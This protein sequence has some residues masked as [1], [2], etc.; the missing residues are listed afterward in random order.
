M[1]SNFHGFP[2]FKFRTYTWMSHTY[3]SFFPFYSNAPYSLPA[4]KI[5]FDH[6]K[7]RV[8]L[9]FGFYFCEQEIILKK[10]PLRGRVQ[11]LFQKLREN[12]LHTTPTRPM[13]RTIQFMNEILKMK[14]K[15]SERSNP[16]WITFL[17]FK[18]RAKIS[19]LSNS[20]KSRVQNNSK[21]FESF[22]NH[23][24]QRNSKK[25]GSFKIH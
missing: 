11:S 18:T 14:T 21:K 22:R 7:G 25:L 15:R 23:R 6:F 24:I 9:C 8:D 4:L 10:Q 13:T 1:V 20:E 16:W 2:I 17:C 19:Y 3:E 12:R 5:S